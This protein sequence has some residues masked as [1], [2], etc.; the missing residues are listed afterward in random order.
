MLGPVEVRRDGALVVVPAGKPTELLMRLALAAGTMV[1]KERL[2]EDLWAED[3]VSTSA[4]TV[5]SK[6][7]RLRRALGDPALVVGGQVGYTLAVDAA[8]V[9]A[10]EVARWADEVTTLRH[11]GDLAAV[12]EASST[13]LA[14]FRGE[15]LFGASDADWLRPHRA[16]LEGLRLRLIED[17]LGARLDL[18]AT[19]EV[20]G[21]LEQLVAAHPLREGLWALLITALYRAGRQADALAAYRA[22]RE[23]LV[24]ELGLEP[25]RDLQRLEQQILE[26]DPALDA[27]TTPHATPVAPVAPVAP[28]QGGNL[29]PLSSSLVGRD[30]ECAEAGELLAAHRLVTL[31]GP[32]GV[33]KTRLALEVARR[34]EPADGA[35]LVRLETART[36]ESVGD[37]IAVALHANGATESALVERLRGANVLIVLDNCEH[38]VDA[39][40]ELVTPL[41]R[42]GLGVRI[43]ATSQLP[44]GVDGEHAYGIDPL[45]FG[46]AVA[47]FT[48]RAGEHGRLFADREVTATIEE[49]CRSLDGLP[50]A[51]ELAA[52][53]TKSLSL[54]EISR[55]LEDRFSLLRD[56]TSRR[57]ERQRTLAGAIAWSYDLLFPDDQRGLWALAGFVGGAPLDG[58]ETV[59]AALG[60]PHAA[61][62]DVVGRL[63]DRSLVTIERQDDGAVRYGLLDSVRTFALDR[64][65]QS[66]EA[67]VALGA[68]AAWV[69]AAAEEADPGAQGNEQH[70]HVAFARIE[71]ANI[72]AAL[73]WTST[74]D[75][76]LGLTIAVHL[77]WVWVV[78]G[79]ALGAQRLLAA[80]TAAGNAAPPELRAAGSML[81]GWLHAAAGDLVLGHA[82]VTFAIE[83]LGDVD[84]VYARARTD[85]FLA[86]VLSQRGEFNEALRL[87]ERS[88]PVFFDLGRRWDEAA[89]WVLTA[90]V[91][92]AGGNQPAATQACVEAARLLEDVGDPWFLTHVEAM[93]GALAQADHR[94]GDACDHL[95]RAAASSRQQGFS[96]SEAYHLANLGRAQQQHGELD[97]AA[98]TL[99]QAIDTARA[100]GDLRVASL[101]RMRLGRVLREQ[102]DLDAARSNL[103]AA[104]AWYR[105]SGGGDQARLADCLATAM[106]PTD[107]ADA[108]ARLESVLAEAGL[109]GDPEVEVL[110]LDAL[111]HRAAAAG[112]LDAAV[113]LLAR[114]DAAMATA[115]LRVTEGD[116]V[117]ALATHRLIA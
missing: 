70:R 78:V 102:G 76:I 8:A 68:H 61:A 52:A 48:Q 37:T 6:V 93:L 95:G 87:L 2:L 17:G 46:D 33:G 14:L 58:V 99:Q 32:A 92:L 67:R 107:E 96:A 71:R 9:D 19:G 53:R 13:A 24:E 26:Q 86:Y 16:Q 97:A 114:A 90:H 44:L 73:E 1:L 34:F 35:W 3:A 88:R 7:S 112:D 66:G 65:D 98:D 79:D 27:P 69:A 103:R 36:P 29:P 40:A 72:D 54:P 20:V 83:Q 104:Q 110:A 77:G 43:L 116:R 85:F 22:V 30:R 10:L 4:N 80:L 74:H 28:V 64:L 115:R 18:G 101:A 21:E 5:Q 11:A 84:D 117:D 113:K 94:Y 63:V 45:P 109:A 47:L 57:P 38:V 25:G 23:R 81:L 15:S 62:V 56:P 42:A 91:T 49:V 51:I 75:P 105:A 31:V 89:N 111:A 39:V 60:V 55:R 108:T 12:V 50:L 41:L 106:E 82:A 100:T 59:L